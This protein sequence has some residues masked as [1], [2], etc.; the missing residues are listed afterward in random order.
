M[1][2][3]CVV[4]VVC[5]H[6]AP[7]EMME[8][9]QFHALEKRLMTLEQELYD[10]KKAMCTAP[11]LALMELKRQVD[12]FKKKLET[13]EHLS[14]LDAPA[15]KV[16]PLRLQAISISVNFTMVNSSAYER[17]LLVKA[18]DVMSNF[19]RCT[20]SLRPLGATPM[21]LLSWVLASYADA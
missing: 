11:C 5:F 10:H 21:R 4:Q 15:S 6:P 14:W 8:T 16:L 2:T 3:V 17:V 7:L 12:S 20:L 18:R 9:N 1:F 13:T 19:H